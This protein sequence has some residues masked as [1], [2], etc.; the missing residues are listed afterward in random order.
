M[1]RPTPFRLVCALLLAGWSSIAAADADE[2]GR[3]L[4]R[5]FGRL[6]HKAHALFHSPLVTAEGLYYA[7]NQLAVM[8]FDG[9]VWRILK[10]PLTFS[11]SIARGPEGEIY[12]GDE[13]QLGYLPR[14]TNA[15][16]EFRSLLERV[17]ADAKPFGVVR[18]IAVWR[19][20][21]FFA[22][23]K[24]IL[25]Y[26]RHTD[27]FTVWPLAGAHRN[28]LLAT[29][30]RLLLHRRGEGLHAFDGDRWTR[31]SAD[32]A[33]TGEADGFVVPRDAE[34]RA[35]VA[36][37]SRTGLFTLGADGSAHRWPTGADAIFARTKLITA[38]RLHD[39]AL[40]IGTESE[41]IVI[42]SA[43]GQLERQ[44]TTEGGLPHNS[45]FALA[46]DPDGGLWASTNGG[47]ARIDWRSAA[48]WF[49]HQHSGITDAGASDFARHEGT[50]YYLSADGLYRLEPS[51]TPAR[52]A[53]FARDERV[54]LQVRLSSLLTHPTGLLL[55]S[56][57]GLQRLTPTGLHL[58]QAVPGGLKCL[59]G[60][61]RDPRR[62]Y[63][64]TENG[65]G[66]GLLAAD[67]TWLDEGLIP[68]VSGECEDVIEADDGSLWISTVN[69]GVY[70]L[71]RRAEATGWAEASVELHSVGSGLPEG[72]SLIFL[73]KTGLGLHFDTAHGLYRFDRATTRFVADTPLTR[74][75]SRPMVLNPV[76]A[77]APD[78]IWTNGLLTDYKTKEVP[79]PLLRLRRDA[80]G[81]IRPEPMPV[82]VHELFGGSG[83]RRI[84][85]EPGGSAGDGV[86][87]GKGE[88]G[89]IRVETHRLRER[90]T[91]RA[92]LLRD[93][94]A[95]GR[96]IALPGAR[97]QLDLRY[98]PE[99][100]TLRF[101]SARFGQPQFERF[102]TRLRG[103]N[104]E[105]SPPT[106]RDEVAYT[107]LERGPYTF[108]VRAVDPQGRPGP[109]ASLTLY[110]APPWHRSDLAYAGYALA[111]LLAIG[112]FVHGRLRRSERE[113]RRL[114]R[115]VSER[116]AEL[117]VAKE[118]ADAANQA[119]SAFLANMS[120]ELRTPLNGVIGYAQVLQHSP[121][122]TDRDRERVRVVQSSGEH[123]LHMINEV[124]DLSKIEAGK[125]ELRIA[126]LHLRQLL[127]DS[128]ANAENRAE[129][130]GLTL[131]LDL[132][133]DVPAQVNG[134]AQKLRQVV[135]NLLS[136][137]VKFTAR[138][139]V[140][141][142]VRREGART[143]FAVRDTGV[144][145]TE[146]DLSRLFQPF[147]QATEGRPA[148][149][150]TGLGLTICQRL[151]ALMGGELQVATRPG[152]GSEF[153]FALPLE[154]C[155]GAT[156]ATPSPARRVNGYEGPRRRILIVDDI[157]L[158]RAVLVELLAPLGFKVREVGSGA[159][160]LDH[161]A[162]VA[163]DLVI[164]DSRMP[165]MSGAELAQ[166]L[167]PAGATT[168]KLL[169][170]SASVLAFTAT[171]AKAAGCDDFLGK[172]FREEE[173]L[174]KLEH[175][176]NLS[177]QY[178]EATRVAA[179]GPAPDRTAPGDAATILR[180]LLAAAQKGEIQGIRHHLK[181]LRSSSPEFAAELE[182][183]AAAYQ[184][185]ALHQRVQRK[186]S[187]S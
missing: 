88:L 48:T 109:A 104:D 183:L 58:V 97:R 181:A 158:N 141:L 1:A 177:W 15:D 47:P 137:A 145:I 124:L 78:E 159:E 53:R 121:T 139:S 42:L 123:L 64:A 168:P 114:E 134:D 87:W 17:P 160:A 69:R 39:G 26:H 5:G 165:G 7:G 30:E 77:G 170:M 122:I 25:Q 136:N 46:E 135:D 154:A 92:P 34:A 80:N 178:T 175:L 131:T 8:E 43:G 113:R 152:E 62:V 28:R 54:D 3:P 128:V 24:S 164:L 21:V 65:V 95:E 63:F 174:G 125:L 44:V 61:P 126:P 106:A 138:G 14:P 163:P 56:A 176:L 67:G 50:F 169:M 172:P 2:R 112:A 93:L 22:T 75:E 85:W 18:D 76:A 19:Q 100:I 81:R 118:Q 171:D 180:C 108:E 116:T 51:T 155:A 111:A 36:G 33:I 35:L 9:R 107:N 117:K 140:T 103:Y 156:P 71:T 157:A 187:E 89:L 70:R 144:G 59:A 57:A 143:R 10:V 83:A 84:F 147:Q 27:A 186:L 167:R 132:A 127:L 99:P 20:D 182:P 148:E 29:R 110:V 173:L 142:E 98:S 68:G 146:A 150:G 130:K 79:Y 60:S 52:P 129:R 32:P 72:H 40:A 133:P 31:L 55:A 4:V 166:R 23:E 91:E 38:R 16:P 49:D 82:D 94:H 11:R 6:E 151:V 120:H 66:T 74:W 162:A 161:A 179:P 149:P 105:W 90:G 101:A 115:L 86:V 41:G 73:W 119:K 45:V 153:F 102:Q 13:E 184:V 12:L 96:Q 185:E 37:V